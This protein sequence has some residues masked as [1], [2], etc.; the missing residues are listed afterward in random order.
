MT[1]KQQLD[2]PNY[3]QNEHQRPL[4]DDELVRIRQVLLDAERSRWLATT[5]RSWAAWIAGVLIAVTMGYD[6]LKKAVISLT[7]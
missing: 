4:S 5:I 7:K 1:D 6:A 3:E 2:W